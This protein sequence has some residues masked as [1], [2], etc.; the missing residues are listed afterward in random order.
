MALRVIT[1]NCCSIR[2]K[3]DIVKDLLN[4]CDILLLQET[5]ISSCQLDYVS[6][7]NNDFASVH[8]PSYEPYLT[9][10][11]GRLS[12]GLSIFWKKRVKCGHKIY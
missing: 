11:E 8:L 7:I 1:Y 5:L 9:G 12:G 10:N 6:N 3:I 4:K 2:K